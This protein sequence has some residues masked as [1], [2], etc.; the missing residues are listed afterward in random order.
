VAEAHDLSVDVP[1]LC[2]R[3]WGLVPDAISE[4]GQRWFTGKVIVRCD[5]T[6][7]PW[8]LAGSP[9]AFQER[10]STG[11]AFQERLHAA[12]C[13][14][15]STI[16]RTLQGELLHRDGGRV[17]CLTGWVEGAPERQQG[18]WTGLMLEQL[19]MAVGEIHRRGRVLVP[20]GAGPEHV[21]EQF[22]A[23]D[24]SGFAGLAGERWLALRADAEVMAASE[25]A[26]LRE[27]I[28]L[29]LETLPGLA[30]A[31]VRH[32]TVTHDDLWTEHVHFGSTG[33]LTGI[34]DLDG[35]DV[36]DAVG[37]L[38][39]L[40]SDL[41]DLRPGRCAD[42]LRGYRTE[43]PVSEDDLKAALATVIRHHLLTLLERIRLWRER[44]ERRH[45]LISSV[46]YW[47][48]LLRSAVQLD[49][50][51]WTGALLE[52]RAAHIRASPEDR[53]E[54]IER[55]DGLG[56]NRVDL[57]QH[58]HRDAEGRVPHTK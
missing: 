51:V 55:P 54:A 52:Q 49:S 34:I 33:R 7:G 36:G 16:R 38:A 48:E 43:C 31:R 19:G 56:D 57:K 39:A 23:G 13:A 3:G 58:N 41:A 15:I 47:L 35:L 22:W 11:S 29:S 44:P 9:D 8:C 4:A 1:D 25:L 2:R 42:V 45:D 21:P 10:V 50:R 27:C 40:L 24:W 32:V 5:A 18:R 26:S 37:D 28:E 17:W 14:A 6:E 46:G 53:L 12:G 20:D 30:S